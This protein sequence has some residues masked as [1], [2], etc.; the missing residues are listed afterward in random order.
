LTE[1]PLIS[2]CN[3]YKAKGLNVAKTYLEEAERVGY[4]FDVILEGLRNEK[5]SLASS[6]DYKK[7]IMRAVLAY[8]HQCSVDVLRYAIELCARDRQYLIP[9]IDHTCVLTDIDILKN[10]L[11]DGCIKGHASDLN[12]LALKVKDCL[13]VA[14]LA[15]KYNCT[16]YAVRDALTECVIQQQQNNLDN[17]IFITITKLMSTLLDDCIAGDG[18]ALQTLGSILIKDTKSTEMQSFSASLEDSMEDDKQ[19]Q[20][21]FAP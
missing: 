5:G 21:S 7:Y 19:A 10:S 11:L 6:S 8:K 14:A 18:Q 20:S 2:W 15:D 4:A 12:A 9:T 17:G 3:L 13:S 16:F 1:K